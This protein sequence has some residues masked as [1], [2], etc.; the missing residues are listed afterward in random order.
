MNLSNL[1]VSPPLQIIGSAMI[2]EKVKTGIFSEMH[3][4]TSNELED[5]VEDIV[6]NPLLYFKNM[7]CPSHSK[8]Y[9][10][11]WF[12]NM[13]T[14]LDINF[15]SLSPW[16]SRYNGKNIKE[17]SDVELDIISRLFPVGVNGVKKINTKYEVGIY[18]ETIRPLLEVFLPKCVGISF[19]DCLSGKFNILTHQYLMENFPNL[20]NVSFTNKRHPKKY[21]EKLI[22]EA[23]QLKEI[24]KWEAIY[25]QWI[26][27]FLQ[28]EQFTDENGNESKYIHKY[29]MARGMEGIDLLYIHE[30][31]R[32]LIAKC[33]KIFENTGIKPL[34]L[35]LDDSMS[36][37]GSTAKSFVNQIGPYADVVVIVTMFEF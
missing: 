4:I 2:N 23:E 18:V 30:A 9:G 3:N 14:S 7:E 29:G 37:F 15:L 20:P 21:W 26:L 24:Y 6:N 1:E 19:A 31:E 36:K 17:F 8:Q 12:R 33:K 16:S 27:P 35:F 28:R 5:R 22:L 32:V 13:K 10:Q 11:Y 34:V 25:T